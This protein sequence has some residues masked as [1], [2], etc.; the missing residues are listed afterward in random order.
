MMDNINFTTKT[1]DIHVCYIDRKTFAIARRYIVRIVYDYVNVHVYVD[2][3]VFIID[4]EPAMNLW[5]IC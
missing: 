5:H 3:Q 4:S 2:V 1:W